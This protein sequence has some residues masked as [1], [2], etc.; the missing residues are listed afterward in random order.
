MNG[1][2]GGYEI[3]IR[4]PWYLFAKQTWWNPKTELQ[5]NIKQVYRYLAY[6]LSSIPII[7]FEPLIQNL[8]LQQSIL[9]ELYR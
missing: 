5:S 3:D 4:Q 7:I 6:L 8:F 9:D 2:G 1:G